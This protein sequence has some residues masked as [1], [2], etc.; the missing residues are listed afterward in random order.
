V[1]CLDA[2]KGWTRLVG[3]TPS[4]SGQVCAVDDDVRKAWRR[5][6][7]SETTIG[8]RRAGADKKRAPRKRRAGV[9]CNCLTSAKR[10]RSAT[11][12]ED[13]R[14][15]RMIGY[16]N[17][18]STAGVVFDDGSN[19][20]TEIGCEQVRPSICQGRTESGCAGR[21]GTQNSVADCGTS[22]NRD[23]ACATNRERVGVQTTQD[24]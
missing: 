8:E 19:T 4:T 11:G 6:A 17:R 7:Q 3:N 14:G 2:G 12:G 22:R 10:L 24:I 18:L 21:R 20:A 16:I 9:C 13:H 1:H 5:E 23:A 15:R